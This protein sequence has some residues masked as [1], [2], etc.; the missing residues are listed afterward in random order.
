VNL[1][2]DSDV[3]VYALHVPG[4]RGLRNIHLKAS[5]LYKSCILGSD[6]LFLPTTIFVESV[7]ALSK[8]ITP[9]FAKAAREDIMGNASEIFPVSPKMPI[10][11]IPDNQIFKN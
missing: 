10:S 8:I 9:E 6:R 7:S 2:L 11:S 1:T 3:L 5:K 4:D